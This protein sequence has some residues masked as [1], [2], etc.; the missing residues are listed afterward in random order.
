M[1]DQRARDLRQP[2][3]AGRIVAL[4][5]HPDERGLE[6]SAQ[7]ISVALGSS[8]TI[9]MFVLFQL[10]VELADVASAVISAGLS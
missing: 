1:R 9:R 8:E 5:G 4:V 3:D 2:R 6:P 7:T 10:L